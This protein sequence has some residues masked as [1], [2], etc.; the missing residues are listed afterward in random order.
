MRLRLIR[1]AAAVALLG[2]ASFM[3]LP[4]TAAPAPPTLKTTT[5]ACSK[6][7]CEIGPGNGH[8]GAGRH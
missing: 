8:P 5:F 2:G 3:A 1:L 6:G 4:G 7:V